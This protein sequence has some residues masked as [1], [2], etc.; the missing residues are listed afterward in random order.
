MKFRKL[1]AVTLIGMMS[2]SLMA[3]GGNSKE[4]GNKTADGKEKEKLVIWS[5]GADEEKNQE[6]LWWRHSRKHIR[7][8]KSSI[9]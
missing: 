7:R 6:R 1:M 4:T 8:S 5:W 2:A 3:C 9:L